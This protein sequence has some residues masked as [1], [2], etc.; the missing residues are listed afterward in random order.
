LL[1]L[2]FAW[3]FNAPVDLSA[4]PDY[5]QYVPQPRDLG[6]MKDKAEAGGYK[7]PSQV[8]ADFQLVVSNAKAYNPPGTDVYYM[9]TLVQV[10]C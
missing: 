7:D 2:Q 3:P 10:G 1:V 9:A 5:T 4:Y 8:Y 6:T